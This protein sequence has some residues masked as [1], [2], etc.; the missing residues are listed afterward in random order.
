[1]TAAAAAVD[2]VAANVGMDSILVSVICN[3]VF[4]SITDCVSGSISSSACNSFNFWVQ[5]WDWDRAVAGGFCKLR[6]SSNPSAIS[7]LQ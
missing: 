1:M 7:K 5:V 3:S 2:C 4:D 6:I